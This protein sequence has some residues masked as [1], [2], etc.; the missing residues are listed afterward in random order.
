MTT[1]KTQNTLITPQLPLCY[2]FIVKTLTPTLTLATPSLFS[3]PMVSLFP[4][5]QINGVIQ[6]VAFCVNFFHLAKCI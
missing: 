1:I 2:A 3:V 4:E 5:C 6:Y